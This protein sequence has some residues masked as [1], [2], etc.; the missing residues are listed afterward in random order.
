[1]A[2]N[3]SFDVN[4][5]RVDV[6]FQTVTFLFHFDTCISQHKLPLILH[7]KIQPNIPSHF[8]E[9]DLNARLDLNGFRVN[10]N[11][12]TVIVTYYASAFFRFINQHQGPTYIPYE[13]QY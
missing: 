11:F 12:Q 10:V 6:N 3:A 8:V 13:F 7:T 4:F 9:I 2:L 5:A 1:M